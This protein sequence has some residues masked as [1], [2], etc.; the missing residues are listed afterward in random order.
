M[1]KK[2]CCII[3]YLLRD[4]YIFFVPYVI[5]CY[6]YIEGMRVGIVVYASTL[7]HLSFHSDCILVMLLLS[8]IYSVRVDTLLGFLMD[9]CFAV[10]IRDPC[11]RGC[12]TTLCVHKNVRV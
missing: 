12:F 2:N 3:I 8:C 6:I 11:V 10:L 1:K 4:K 9:D 7:E 5:I